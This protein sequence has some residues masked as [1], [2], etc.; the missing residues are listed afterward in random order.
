VLKSKSIGNLLLIALL[1]GGSIVS[2][3]VGLGKENESYLFQDPPSEKASKSQRL[4]RPT[5]DGGAQTTGSAPSV[6][7]AAST[8]P[9]KLNVQKLDVSA[10]Q[11]RLD[12]GT[13][14]Q[15][16]MEMPPLAPRLDARIGSMD[17]TPFNLNANKLNGIA[18]DQAFPTLKGGVNSIRPLAD[19]DVE[20]IIDQSMSMRKRDCPGGLSRWQWCGMQTRDLAAALAHVAPRGVTLTTFAYNY[21]TLKAATPLDVEQRFLSNNFGLGTRMSAPLKN[22]LKDYLDHKTPKSRPLLIAVITDG[23]PQPQPVQP[24]LVADTLVSASKRIKDPRDVTVVFFQVGGN[25]R[26]GRAFLGLL[27]EGLVKM[28]AHHDFVRTVGFDELQRVGLGQSLVDS[29]KQ[30]ATANNQRAFPP[31]N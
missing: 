19:Y 5:G 14:L 26:F 4:D 2:A 22:R 10:D 30:F 17:R 21:D 7:P 11:N 12:A 27:D 24:L 6:A 1:L 3:P 13:R 20:L 23:V 29:V 16:P 25:D 15:R 28:G 9:F 31:S 18:V 8:E